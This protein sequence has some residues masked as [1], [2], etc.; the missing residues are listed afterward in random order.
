MEI[1]QWEKIDNEEINNEEIILYDCVFD[2]FYDDTFDFNKV[3]NKSIIY[4]DINICTCN[5]CSLCAFVCNRDKVHSLCEC[6]SKR[7]NECNRC[8]NIIYIIPNGKYHFIY[9]FNNQLLIEIELYAN[10]IF[11]DRLVLNREKLSKNIL[12]SIENIE[13]D[14]FNS[15]SDS[16]D[17]LFTDRKI[18]IYDDHLFYF[19]LE[20]FFENLK[21]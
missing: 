9:K 15:D 20:N 6:R 4:I 2:N 10:N 21:K 1:I 14:L 18:N 16:E 8:S 13:S 12:R 19:L 17:D 11:K 5:Y 7:S 3:C